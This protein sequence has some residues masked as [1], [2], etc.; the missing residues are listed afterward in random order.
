[1]NMGNVDV[2]VE[3]IESR[4]LKKKQLLRPLAYKIEGGSGKE[5]MAANIEDPNKPF[6]RWSKFNQIDIVELYHQNKII[7]G[8]M[9]YSASYGDRIFVFDSENNQNLFVDNPR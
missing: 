5:L 1:M 8:K 3:T 4:I 7:K 6:R 2:L 9:E